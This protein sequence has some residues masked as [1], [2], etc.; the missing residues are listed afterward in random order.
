MFRTTW[1]NP[2]SGLSP[3]FVANSGARVAMAMNKDII[4]SDFCPSCH[5]E[6][7]TSGDKFIMVLKLKSCR[8]IC[9]TL[10]FVLQSSFSGMDLECNGPATLSELAWQLIT[11]HKSNA[12]SVYIKSIR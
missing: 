12:K 11:S 1:F 6:M 4:L 8:K 10:I 7:T 3:G 2:G 5:E 9:Y